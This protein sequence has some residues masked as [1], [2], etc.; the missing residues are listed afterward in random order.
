MMRRHITRRSTCCC[1]KGDRSCN[2]FY[3]FNVWME[4]LITS[5]ALFYYSVV[6]FARIV[7]LEKCISYFV[8]IYPVPLIITSPHLVLL[9]LLLFVLKLLLVVVFVLFLL[10]S[11][12]G[13][14]SMVSVWLV[15]CKGLSY[16]SIIVRPAPV[17]GAVRT[18]NE[19]RHRSINARIILV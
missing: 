4:E 9:L 15:G 19:P 5:N 10:L 1:W 3:L 14:L 2:T 13:L 6:H 16:S 12:L 8:N 11:F 17:G 7:N 18:H